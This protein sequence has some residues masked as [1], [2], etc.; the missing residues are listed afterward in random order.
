[1]HFI[2]FDIHTDL[3]P[4][5]VYDLGS[6]DMTVY[7]TMRKLPE[8]K[9]YQPRTLTGV[10][11]KGGKQALTTDVIHSRV[12]DFVVFSNFI[13]PSHHS[14][15]WLTSHHFHELE[16][17]ARP[18]GELDRFL[19][20]NLETDLEQIYGFYKKHD[21]YGETTFFPHQNV[22]EVKVNFQEL[23]A[24]YSSLEKNDILRQ[25]ISLF[26]LNCNFITLLNRF[27]DNSN[28]EIS[29]M[30]SIVDSLMK[31]YDQDQ[32]AI[33][34][35]VNCGHQTTGKKKDKQRIKDF[36]SKLGYNTSDQ[37]LIFQTL[38]EHYKVRND[39]F[40][41]AKIVPLG[42]TEKEIV[43]K[44]GSNLISLEDELK[45]GQGRL[46]GFMI[47]KELVQIL[48]IKK[49]KNGSQQRI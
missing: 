5:K 43:D 18:I 10:I 9:V 30:Y 38:W 24:T 2:N 21:I 47:I 45:Y 4:D 46:S 37:D 39:F 27:Y 28:L 25:Q 1:M 33:K 7:P 40:H 6:V 35:C 20:E 13:F 12:K 48:L 36:V 34:Q 23:L 49:L 15:R 11:L 41:E 8:T 32:N 17:L 44:T 19:S 26:A 16:K 3:V 31:E 29:L 42:D 22:N 14:V